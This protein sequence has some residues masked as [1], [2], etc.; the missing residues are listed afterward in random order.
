MIELLSVLAGVF[1]LL[2]G[3]TLIAPIHCD[4]LILIP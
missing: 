1:V 2:G 4:L 3:V